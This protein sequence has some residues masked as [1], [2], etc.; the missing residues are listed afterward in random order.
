MKKNDENFVIKRVKT[1]Y[2]VILNHNI[3]SSSASKKQTQINAEKV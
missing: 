2:S 3:L 1:M